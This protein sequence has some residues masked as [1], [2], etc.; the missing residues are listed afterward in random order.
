MNKKKVLGRIVG[1]ITLG[2]LV[3]AC[4]SEKQEGESLSSTEAEV[5]ET[6]HHRDFSWT[7]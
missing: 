5:K 3:T 7:V 6:N 1:F 2:L 4:A